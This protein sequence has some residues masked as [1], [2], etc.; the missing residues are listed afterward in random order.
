MRKKALSHLAARDAKQMVHE[1]AKAIDVQNDHLLLKLDPSA[2]MPG[3]GTGEWKIRLPLPE[4]TPRKEARLR[5]DPEGTSQGQ[6]EASLTKLLQEAFQVRKFVIPIAEIAKR[7]GRCPK[8][9][10]KL[11]RLSWISPRIV[12]TILEGRQPASLTRN[13]LLSLELPIEWNAQERLLRIAN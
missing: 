3:A 10:T 1:L 4:R 2:L 9:M 13:R 8:Q 11:L 12:E 6:V 7:E 5:I